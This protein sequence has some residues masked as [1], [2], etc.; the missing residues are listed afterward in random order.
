MKMNTF[1]LQV[2]EIDINKC[3]QGF[4]LDFPILLKDS[5]NRLI[6]QE[7]NLI[8][9][10]NM[11][12]SSSTNKIDE[13][14]ESEQADQGL[15]RVYSCNYCRRKF[16][17]WQALGGHQN[18]HKRERTVETTDRLH[19]I[20]AAAA[21]FRYA[22]MRKHH[23]LSSS[24]LPIVDHQPAVGHLPSFVHGSVQQLKDG[25][26]GGSFQLQGTGAGLKGNNSSNQ[27]D[28][29]YIDLALKL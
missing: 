7:L 23:Q 28:A 18:A 13:E 15:V 20:T 17:R 22:N 2:E 21:S 16:F 26:L 11:D 5:E 29:T 12:S 4:S 9:S 19:R 1:G 14:A 25:L 27:G 10:F 24:R 6:S 8:D 3:S